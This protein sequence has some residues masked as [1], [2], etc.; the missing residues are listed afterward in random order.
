LWVYP[1]KHAH[2]AWTGNEEGCSKCNLSVL[3]ASITSTRRMIRASSNHCDYVERS[4]SW[5][6]SGMAGPHASNPFGSL[7]SSAML[8]TSAVI[9]MGRKQHIGRKKEAH[10]AL[11]PA[12][13]FP[14]RP[15]QSS[16]L[17]PS[18]SENSMTV[19]SG[20]RI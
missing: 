7:P 19:L 6:P 18:H 14:T 1:A 16:L 2:Y 15:D 13:R 5:R 11:R 4:L 20:S 9:R 12:R 8:A 10:C 3:E 17:V